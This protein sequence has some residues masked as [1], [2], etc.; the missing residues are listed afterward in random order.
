RRRRFPAHS[1]DD[2]AFHGCQSLLDLPNEIMIMVLHYIPIGDRLLNVASTCRHLQQ[3]CLDRSLTTHL[4]LASFYQEGVRKG[5][6]LR[7]GEGRASLANCYWLHGV[8]IEHVS[9][10]RSLRR[11]DLTGCALTTLCLSKIL[12]QTKCLNSLGLDIRKGFQ[13]S[14]LKDN[15]NK[16]LLQI[17]E[18]K[19]TLLI[20]S[21]GILFLCPNIKK[22]LLYITVTSD[23][24]GVMDKNI[25][26]HAIGSCY[27][28]LTSLIFVVFPLSLSNEWFLW[29]FFHF[30][31]MELKLE[32]RLFS[33]IL[34]MFSQD[35][36]SNSYLIWRKMHCFGLLGPLVKSFEMTN[37]SLQYV[38]E[39]SFDR[40]L[41]HAQHAVFPWSL[42][43]VCSSNEV[44]CSTTSLCSD[45]IIYLNLMSLRIE[46]S[47]YDCCDIDVDDFSALIHA[48]PN[49]QSLSIS[50]CFSWPE[51][52]N[53]SMLLVEIAKL[54]HLRSLS[55][56]LCM[57]GTLHSIHRP[58]R[59]EENY[60]FKKG[61]RIGVPSVFGA[62][63]NEQ[64]RN[65]D[66][67]FG[68]L[69]SELKNIQELEI[70]GASVVSFSHKVCCH[71]KPFG[72]LEISM[73]AMLK[74]LQKLTLSK[75]PNVLNGNGLVTIT[76]CCTNLQ[77]LSLT[78]LGKDG[79]PCFKHSLC[80]ALLHCQVLR[81][82][83]L[84]QPNFI[85]DQRFFASLQKCMKLEQFCLL[86][87][88]GQ[89]KPVSVLQFVGACP[90]LVACLIYSGLSLKACKKLEQAILARYT[91]LPV[92]S[93]TII[94][95]MS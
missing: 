66:S 36:L 23:A 7:G 26:R 3:L 47:P 16:T 85:A 43:G 93:Q 5:E 12:A 88:A 79:Q 38:S 60:L 92:F 67:P 59:K 45:P 89:V 77:E 73:I 48:C 1:R 69:M 62:I 86:S 57:L 74:D 22:L 53:G 30:Q 72:D 19:Q 18:L 68:I 10:C 81:I 42:L 25:D 95:V 71:P 80:E 52:V 56:P 20:K 90:R 50:H 51:G 37:T 34:I 76:S 55:L 27:K 17:T 91:L 9:K 21:Y 83:R 40:L 2:D 46:K 41:R 32:V 49:L 14:L 63:A 84:Q 58:V 8:T 94:C 29:S 54:R 61:Q 65:N 24:M 33:I 13:E 87:Q 78:Y 44:L 31:M 11:L 4:H 6:R 15:A 82:F 39:L 64:L 28:N 35:L 75:I 70:M